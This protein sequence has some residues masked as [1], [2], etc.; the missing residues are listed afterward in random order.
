MGRV[1][2]TALRLTTLGLALGLVSG[3]CGEPTGPPPGTQDP[4][5]SPSATGAPAR[6][7]ADLVV[8]ADEEQAA[9]V[10]DVVSAFGEQAGASTAV[11]ALPAEDLVGAFV[12]ANAEGV[13]PDVLVA[14][15]EDLGTLLTNG[16]VD[17]LP[18]TEPDTARYLPTA[19]EAVRDGDTVHGLPY[20][21]S[22]VVLFRDTDLV[23]EE[24]ATVEALVAA[25]RDAGAERALCV[26]VGQDGSAR[27]LQPL[28][29]SAG[30]ELYGP[31]VGGVVD[32]GAVLLASPASVTA[33][34]RLAR[35][36][37][38][39]VIDPSM[40]E[41]AALD[42]F[43][44]GRCPFLV[45]QPEAV[46]QIRDLGIPYAVSAVPPF[47]GGGPARPFTRVRA[48]MPASKAR[49]PELAREL[50]LDGVNRPDSM[51]DLHAAGGGPP[52][53][54]EVLAA[55]A[56]EDPDQ[57][58]FAQVA[59]QGQLVPVDTPAEPIEQALGRAQA[60][61]L[62]GADPRETMRAAA[63]EVVAALQ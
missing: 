5:E 38:D 9:V 16:A 15:H 14:T 23:P 36:G 4:L 48:L 22:S 3:A 32:P 2:T 58:V 53:M 54:A 42:L 18:L 26:P 17:P 27:H 7:D 13:G 62:R 39:G 6:A 47:E 52:A 61:V 28:W 59:G 50:V 37:A 44:D 56:E 40:T 1:R 35:L 41:R 46:E 30:G 21:L 49:S 55:V 12:A 33:A 11:Q 63:A 10:E 29:S 43:L 57:A 51:A 45:A 8:W 24:P 34:E 31:T 20:A 60:A 19:V 25:A